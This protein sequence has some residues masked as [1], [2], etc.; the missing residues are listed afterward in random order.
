[1]NFLITLLKPWNIDSPIIKWPIL[2]SLISL[3]LDRYFVDLKSRPCP[4]WTSKPIFFANFEHFLIL[5]N[6]FLI[7]FLD[8][9][10]VANLPVWISIQS[11][12]KFLEIMMSFKDG[13]IKRLVLILLCLNKLNIDFIFFLFFLRFNPPSVVISFLF[14][15]TIQ[16]KSGFIL[17][18]FLTIYW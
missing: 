14:S 7:F 18:A 17:R 1:M 5:V 3:I 11:A 2:N 4:A 13:L 15:G 12:P 16:I 10:R 6:S 8:L 9:T